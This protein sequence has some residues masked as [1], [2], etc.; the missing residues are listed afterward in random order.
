VVFNDQVGIELRVLQV[1]VVLPKA[2]A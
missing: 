1:V 2:S